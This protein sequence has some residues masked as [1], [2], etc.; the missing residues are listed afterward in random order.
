MASLSE[1]LSAACLL[2]TPASL[3]SRPSSRLLLLDAAYT[4]HPGGLSWDQ[5]A[6]PEPLTTTVGP[7]L[8][9]GDPRTPYPDLRLWFLHPISLQ[10]LHGFLSP[11]SPSPCQDR[12]CPRG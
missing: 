11:A 10:E 8:R 12:I 9:A 3:D 6:S 7:L 1:P 5:S 2:W 4:R